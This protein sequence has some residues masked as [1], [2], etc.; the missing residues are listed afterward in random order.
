[1]GN[2]SGPPRFGG[3][4]PEFDESSTP[5]A[6]SHDDVVQPIAHDDRGGS[7]EFDDSHTPTA[8]S[9]DDVQPVA[10]NFD[11]GAPSSLSLIHI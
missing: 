9:H 4:P 8:P 6:P 7:P 1:M 3:G 10:P 5:A 2:T 11:D